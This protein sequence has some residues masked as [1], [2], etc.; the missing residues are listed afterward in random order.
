MTDSQARPDAP[1]PAD[2]ALS[3]ALWRI[4]DLHVELES[5][6]QS[7]AALRQASPCAGCASVCCREVFCRES[8]ESDF[9]R[10]VLGPRADGY[11]ARSGWHDPAS[12]CRLSHGRPLV[13]YEFLCG[14][15]DGPEWTALRQ[16]SR[17]FKRVYVQVRA[18][19]NLLVV[20]DI[21]RVGAGRLAVVQHRLE[22]L[23]EQANAALRGALDD[24]FGPHAGRDGPPQPGVPEGVRR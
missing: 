20:D 17:A 9:L 13:C 11:S 2:R 3:E 6:L 10:F 16:L 5:I 14:E 4:R 23:R 12:G 22:K 19:R 1:P 7:L 21:G 8:V 18:G 24:T 15:F